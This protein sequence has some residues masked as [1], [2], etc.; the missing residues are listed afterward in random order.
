VLVLT[1][2]AVT[3]LMTAVALTVDAGA[4]VVV[5]PSEPATGAG[6][7][8]RAGFSPGG[9]IFNETDAEL[10]RTLDAMAATGA[11]WV[12]FDFPWASVEPNAPVLDGAS[13]TT[14]R[15]F[16]WSGVDRLV[17]A[18]HARG[19]KVIALPYLTPSWARPAGTN[20]KQPP[21]DIGLYASFVE[22]AVRR[23]APKGVKVWEIWNEPNLSNF[24]SPKPDPLRYTTLLKAA[25]GAVRSVDPG[26]TIVLGG[27]SPAVDASDG[28]QISPKTFLQRVYALGGGPSFDAV[29]MHPYSYPALPLDPTSASWNTFYRLPLIR[30]VMVANGDGAKQIWSTEFGAPTGTSPQAVSEAEQSA[31]VTDAYNAIAKWDWHGPLLWY[32]LRDDGTDLADREQNFGL[33]RRDYSAKSALRTFDVVTGERLAPVDARYTPLPPSRILDTRYGNGAP[34]AKLGAG[35][36]LDLQVTGRGGVP[37]SGVSAVVM[38]VTATAPTAASQVTVWPTGSGRPE[39]ISVSF[40][41]GQTIAGLVVAKLGPD[42]RVSL[43]NRSGDTHVIA[44]VVGWYDDGTAASGARFSPLA[45]SRI[46]DTRF[47]N[48]APVAKV[49][50]KSSIELQV[51]G[52]GGV[53]AAGVSAVVMN[54]TVTEPTLGS[55]LTVWPAGTAR[56]L[57][58]NLNYVGRQTVPNLVVAKVGSGGKVSLFNNSGHTH[59]IA[60][61]V[62]YYGAE[63]STTGSRFTALVPDR[64]LDT[65]TGNGAPAIK[66]GRGSIDLQVTG[67]GGVP[68]AGVSGVV[69]TVTATDPTIGSHL[70][71]WPTGAARPVAS[72]LNF[73]AG[74][75][76]S[77]SVFVKTGTGGKVSIFNNSGQ[78]HVVAEVVGWY[79][80]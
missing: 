75:T 79:S 13:P 31:M 38:N 4:I 80:G 71:V 5:S 72:N 18:A 27:L 76:I 19:L 21:D 7:G 6:I 40:A 24:W 15:S 69:L 23:Y 11:E 62:G 46:L 48:G 60:D 14:P 33:L 42:G 57:A 56:P 8:A 39:T 59:L 25:A 9:S 1:S 73:V 28:N 58:S 30:D 36:S 41:S 47:G 49:G 50:P 54:V 77:N 55:H 68:A 16:E 37:S 3:M 53:P 26:A 22:A 43:F 12:R 64:V 45:P 35:R 17:D 29:G 34:T 70:T 67:R 66:L 74:T 65:R 63:G 32:S 61:V 52:R 44:D 78:T 51:T 2:V 10:A 20:E